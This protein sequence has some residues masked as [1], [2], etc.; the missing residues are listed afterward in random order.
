MTPEQEREIRKAAQ[1]FAS[2]FFENM[3]VGHPDEIT[4]AW[5]QEMHPELDAEEAELYR[6]FCKSQTCVFRGCYGD[7]SIMWPAWK[8]WIAELKSL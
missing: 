2:S 1:A 8:A 3:A 7:G 5:L 6:Q 4:A